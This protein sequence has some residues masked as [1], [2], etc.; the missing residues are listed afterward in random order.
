MESLPK[1]NRRIVACT[2]CPQ[3]NEYCK[4]IAVQKRRMYRDWSYWGKPVPSFG[5]LNASILLLGLAPAAHGANRTGRMFTGDSSGDWL[6]EALHKYGF[7][8]QPQ[9]IDAKDGMKLSGVW[10]SA[11]CHCAPPD[12]KPSKEEIANCSAHLQAEFSALKSLK[13]I[14]VTGSIA[15][16]SALALL[17]NN[18]I[19]IPKPK[20]KFGHNKVIQLGGITLLSTYHPSRQNTQTGRLTKPMFH[21]VFRKARTVLTRCI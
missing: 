18:G 1:I 4:K 21:S 12:N 10:I 2:K 17:R 14:L 13:I 20:P 11:V 6:Y 9:S 19:D 15:F 3:L 5:D 7:A 8:S 16:E